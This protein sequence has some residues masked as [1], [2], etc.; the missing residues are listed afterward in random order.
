M[1]KNAKSN[2]IKS[3][4]DM[5][6]LIQ[7]ISIKFQ[8]L[9]RRCMFLAN[10]FRVARSTGKPSRTIQRQ[11]TRRLRP[12]WPRPTTMS[13]RPATSPPR[14]TPAP[15]TS[16]IRRLALATRTTQSQNTRG[17]AWSVTEGE[18]QNKKEKN[19]KKKLIKK[20]L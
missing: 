15:K 8:L 9:K 10:K 1:I 5:P 17:A 16:S 14:T 12:R 19:I 7:L 3:R 13:I 20:I 6:H 18:K 4:T 11:F 2:H